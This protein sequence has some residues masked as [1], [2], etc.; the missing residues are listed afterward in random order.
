MPFGTLEEA[1]KDAQREDLAK[2]LWETTEKVLK[3]FGWL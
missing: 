1:S 3:D 2:E